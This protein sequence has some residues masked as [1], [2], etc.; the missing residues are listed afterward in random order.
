MNQLLP[1]FIHLPSVLLGM[2]FTVTITAV[3]LMSERIRNLKNSK[4]K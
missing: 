3:V 1:I 4:T 2:A